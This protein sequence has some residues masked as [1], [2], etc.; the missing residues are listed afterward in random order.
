MSKHVGKKMKAAI[1]LYDPLKV[2]LA[3]EAAGIVK[4]VSYAKFQGPINIAIKLNLD[5]TKAEQQLRG[6]ISLPNGTGKQVRIVALADNVSKEDAKEAGI[7]YLG[8]KE[9]IDKI[10]QGWLDFDLIITIPKFMPELSKLGKILGPRGLMPNPKT[11]TVTT[12]IIGTAKSFKK[13]RFEYRTDSYGII[14]CPIG[15]ISFTDEQLAQNI[16]F[17]IETIRTRRPSTVKGDFI[18]SVVVVPTMGPAV[19]VKF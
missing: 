19:K 12:D 9:L 16:K 5:T 11:Q 15:Q 2:Y 18:Q 4:K 17:M 1:A 3:D 8:G 7:D 6:T 14:H 10:K 13:G